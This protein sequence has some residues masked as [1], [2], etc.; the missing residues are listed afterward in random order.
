MTGSRS[1]SD[2]K[3]LLD[4]ATKIIFN[5]QWSKK[6]F[7]Q[8]IG[9]SFVNSEKLLVIYQSAKKI[10]SNKTKKLVTKIH[11]KGIDYN[12]RLLFSRLGLGI[13]FSGN[14]INERSVSSASNGFGHGGLLSCMA[15]TELKS[16]LSIAILI[17]YLLK[18]LHLQMLTIQPFFAFPWK[19]VELPL[20]FYLC[21][22]STA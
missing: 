5:S 19:M 2:R 11:V 6:R 3:K 7:L 22:L 1:I 15:W 9:S 12:N 13:R 17:V 10:V 16:N 8:N 21:N 20:F 14:N 18:Q 4:H